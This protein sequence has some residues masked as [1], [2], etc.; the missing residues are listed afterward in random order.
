M[1]CTFSGSPQG[2]VVLGS[3]WWYSRSDGRSPRTL[4]FDCVY[5]MRATFA[6]RM[7]L[8]QWMRIFSWNWR[9][10]ERRD[11]R[12]PVRWKPECPIGECVHHWIQ[13]LPLNLSAEMLIGRSWSKN[14]WARIAFL[15]KVEWFAC[16]RYEQSKLW[17]GFK[18]IIVINQDRNFD[19]G[20][21]RNVDR[22][23]NLT[24]E[25]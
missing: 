8:S 17:Q 24:H 9:Q 2:G 7:R 22:Y 21:L 11:N 3:L 13:W 1:R 10:R 15:V 25:L 4:P 23:R 5:Y 14:S 12:K 16:Y 20:N 6:N 19:L 18:G